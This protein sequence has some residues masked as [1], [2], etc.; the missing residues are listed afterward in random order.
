MICLVELILVVQNLYHRQIQQFEWKLH[1]SQKRNKID[2]FLSILVWIIIYD[3]QPKVMGKVSPRFK[4]RY[5]MSI[6]CSFP[7]QRNLFSLN[8]NR[9]HRVDDSSHLIFMRFTIQIL[10]WIMVHNV[11]SITYLHRIKQSDWD[12]KL[13][14]KWNFFKNSKDIYNKSLIVKSIPIGM[15]LKWF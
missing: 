3:T 9:F 1:E 11:W 2:R 12:V 10:S 15:S 7:S 14:D 13:R 6:F 5:S 8:Q 4:C